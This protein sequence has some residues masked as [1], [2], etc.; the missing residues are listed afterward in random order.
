MMEIAV[1]VAAFRRPDSLSRCLEGLRLQTLPAA[2]VVVIVDPID[3]A[4]DRLVAERAVDWP[5]LRVA[6]PATHGT[7]A[8]Y[9]RGIAATRM[10][11]IAF[12]DDDA[13]PQPEWL[14][15]IVRTFEQDER[16]AGVG[17]RDIVVENGRVLELPR[18]LWGRRRTPTVGRI[19][20]FG[21]MIA[22]H[23]VGVGG[24]RDVDVLKGVNM[25][26][27]RVAVA[28][29]GFDERV[30]GHGAQVHS[31]LSICL[32]LRRRG[33]RIV[34][35]PAIAVVH[36]PAPRL[37]GDQRDD[38]SNEAIANAAHNEA[39]QI[40]DYCDALRRVMFAVW[41]G[42]VGTTAA[43]GLA[44]LGRDLLWG[45]PAAWGRFVAAQRGRLAAWNTHRR[46]PRMTPTVGPTPHGEN[47]QAPSESRL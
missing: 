25:S 15:L 20:W 28:G 31:E 44:V 5:E 17:G 36:H 1:V 41:G 23:H 14:E 6:R 47:L 29:H 8:A 7:V 34:Y 13:V 19:T 9:N 43:P 35:D 16:I 4:S 38:I 24:P 18:R 40:L 27:R 46:T 11:L 30:R 39:L 12:V 32:P 37:A 33:L 26:F 3:E 10:E 42:A 22:N 2:E 45:R 21:R